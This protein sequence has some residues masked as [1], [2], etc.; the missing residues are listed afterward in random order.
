MGAMRK[1]LACALVADAGNIP[2]IGAIQ[3]SCCVCERA[4]WMAPSS[5]KLIEQYQ[6]FT[7]YCDYHAAAFLAQHVNIPL[8]IATVALAH[9]ILDEEE[10]N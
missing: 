4:I 10:T 2:A 5:V 9:T 8:E 3:S 1:I 7:P 6:D